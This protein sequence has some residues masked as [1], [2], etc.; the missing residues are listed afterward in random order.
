MRQRRA[1]GIA[2]VRGAG[3][4]RL[5]VRRSGPIDA[6]C[7]AF[8][9]FAGGRSVP[10]R[11]DATLEDLDAGRPLGFS[12]CRRLALPAGRTRLTVEPETLTPYLLRLRSQAASRLAPAPA[13]AVRSA[14]VATRGGRTG[15]R[16][17]LDGPARLILAEGYNHGRRASCDGR[18]LGEPEVGAAFGTA[19]RVPADCRSVEITFAPNRWV[20][21]GYAL[22]LVVGGA[23]AGGARGRLAT[24]REGG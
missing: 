7:G 19:W 8:D 13:G 22:S 4:P 15:I 20:N 2:E 24:T 21:A 23:A 1:V 18:D 16:L 3:V 14:G 10:V 11:F 17:A 9:V 6:G 12:G 5:R